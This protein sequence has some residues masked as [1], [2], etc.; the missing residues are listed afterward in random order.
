[1]NV[2]AKSTVAVFVAAALAGGPAA[3]AQATEV[4]Y[5]P[6]IQP[7]D[8]GKLGRHDLKV[9]AWQT[10]ESMPNDASYVVEY[11]R[12]P[13][14][15]RRAVVK[16]HVVDDYL[17]ADPSLPVPPTAS[18]AHVN[19]YSVLKGLDDGATYYYRVSGPG[20]PEGG[21]ASSFRA[22][23]HSGR[24]SFEVVGDEGYFPAKPN[25]NPPRRVNYEARIVHEMYKA[26]NLS[27]PGAPRLPEP[28]IAVNTG[29]NVYFDGSEDNYRDFWMPVWN[30][31]VS[32]N[33]TGAPFIRHIPY[34]IVDGN[35]DLG[36]TGISANLLASDN[37]GKYSG[38]T[39]GGDALQFF[40]NFYFPLNGPL[41]VDPQYIF[42]GDTS[43]PTG[44]YFS[45]NGVDYN[46]PAAIE[47]FRASTTV[48]TGRGTKRQIDM[49][50]NYSFDE[51]N[52]HFVFLDANP[53]LFGAILS[54]APTYQGPPQKFPPYPS[55]LRKWLVND[56][57]ASDQTWKIVVFHQPAFSSGN[58]TMRNWQ[59]RRIAKFLEDHGV[60]VVFNG[61]EHN[62]QRT[63]P[64]RAMNTVADVPSVSG[65]PAV[66]ID[67]GFD[68]V[69]DTVPDG[70]IYVV[71]GAGGEGSHDSDLEPTRG[72]GHGVDQDD[73]A[74]GTY[75]FGS[76]LTFPNG[77]ASWLDDHLTG[78][79]MRPFMPGAGQGPK[80]T[81]H[82]KA[83]VFS[84]GDVVVDR[85]RLSLYQISEPLQ[86][87]SSATAADPAPY[88]TDY[89]GNPL[90]DP[91]PDTVLDPATGKVVSDPATGTPALLDRFTITK[92]R[93]GHRLRATLH[94][95]RHARRGAVVSYTLE[96]DNRTGYALN[97]TQAVV[98]LPEGVEFAGR[99]GNEATVHGRKVVLTLGRLDKGESRRVEVPVT[100]GRGE[101]GEV[102]RGLTAQVRSATVMPVRAARAR[103]H[104]EERHGR[105]GA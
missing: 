57:D 90:N 61:H 25:S 81:A 60:N 50:G 38:G 102:L 11:G 67:S 39:G 78:A 66:A 19:Y 73:S 63:Y 68:G 97:G 54:Y 12:T 8:A 18:G 1:M 84:F 21:F 28:D 3:E 23:T 99:L 44:F 15:G 64:L 40:N 70:V 53:H 52:A 16:S 26:H 29:D 22:R 42:N 95:P 55:I 45:Y 35:H 24:F 51:G 58:L 46:S 93:V 27:V 89:L 56:L 69:Q 7:G 2:W 34:Y 104:R 30:N 71:E 49:M 62:Y 43:S 94:A 47:A 74:T 92:P 36:S 96:V 17:S 91:I 37:A 79:E 103:A 41:G 14:Y 20:L 80:I 33:E 48:D 87:T 9:I 85:N 100:A 82:F 4:T 5:Q 76:D 13:R 6:Y 77:P 10:D 75:S 65:P 88:G 98:T 83:K 32:S 101:R 86:A 72:V 31:D 105:H 59:M